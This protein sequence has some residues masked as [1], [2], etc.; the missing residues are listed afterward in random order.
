M[1]S[2]LD[3]P[4]SA[5]ELSAEEE[6]WFDD[7]DDSDDS[8]NFTTP[9]SSIGAAVAAEVAEKYPAGTTLVRPASRTE[10]S[11]LFFDI[12]TVPDYSRVGSF[13]LDPLPTIR[14]EA[15]V[16]ACP[17]CNELLTE[18]LDVLEKKLIGL[19]PT[20]EYLDLLLE[21]ERSGPKPRKGVIDAANAVKKSR[22]AVKNA[23][24][25]RSKLLS[26][27]PEYCRLAAIGWA[28]G[29]G[30]V[31]SLTCGDH[32]DCDT[33]DEKVLLEAFWSLA[34]DA[35]PLVG[36]NVLNFDLK[37]V[38]VRS[39]LLG[40]MPS[41]L[42]DAKPWGNRDVLDLMEVRFGRSQAMGLK[43]LAPLYGIEVPAGDC[44]GSQVE[45]LMRVDPKKVGEYVR[46]DV[47]VTREFYRRMSGYFCP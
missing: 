25:E 20:D 3:A 15:G 13:G 1:P 6:N 4:Q 34:L 46:S 38:F 43:K 32:A 22:E 27:T 28:T 11:A 30:E 42:F 18:K 17:P 5:E 10:L 44:D 45:E 19:N 12:E 14:A 36:F 8:M 31:E 24:R 47:T 23:P 29:S 40:V 26:V 16:D 39:I 41:R 7:P 21:T 35:R 2:L 9:P 37:V 33:T